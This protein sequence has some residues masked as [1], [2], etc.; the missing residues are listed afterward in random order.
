LVDVAAWN[1]FT[2]DLIPSERT[3]VSSSAGAS[4]RRFSLRVN[5]VLKCG[6]I[7]WVIGKLLALEVHRVSGF[8]VREILGFVACTENPAI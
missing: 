2:H 7:S 1:C 8:Y 4:Y 6:F 5:A 3:H